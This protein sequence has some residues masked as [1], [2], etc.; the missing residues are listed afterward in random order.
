MARAL[1]DRAAEALAHRRIG[2]ALLFVFGVEEASQHFA[3]ALELDAIA[4]RPEARCST[5]VS[6]AIC[7]MAMGL[8]DEG[9]TLLRDARRA[10]HAGGARF[11]DALVDANLAWLAILRGDHAAACALA[12]PLIERARALDAPTL[13]VG[14][15]CTLGTALRGLGRLDD[16]VRHLEAGVALQRTIGHGNVVAQDLAD[17]RRVSRSGRPRRGERARGKRSPGSA[18]RRARR[19]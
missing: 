15:L 4:G 17:W 1:G 8:L 3:R 12:T 10:A 7:A 5:A 6:A 13:E 2:N 14:G 18:A 9:E 11:G 19:S 16:A